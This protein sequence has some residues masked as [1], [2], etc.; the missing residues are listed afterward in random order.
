MSNAKTLR[1]RTT[2]LIAAVTL[3]FA[4]TAAKAAPSADLW[5]R[6]LP[7]DPVSPIT[8]DHYEW[9]RMLEMYLKPGADGVNRFDYGA[10]TPHDRATF[11]GYLDS[12]SQVPI[13]QCR[14]EEQL[15]FWINLYNALTV[16]T[17]L[18]H[19][20]VDSIRD[21]DISPGLFSK[22]PWKRK[23]FTVEGEA[24][25][26]DDIEH[27]ILRPVWQD[28]R[29]HY[30]LNCA[31]VGCP[32]LNQEAFTA[33]NAEA[34]MEASA[35]AYVNSP[36]GVSVNARGLTLSSIFRWYKDDFGDTEEAL[37][38]HIAQ[39]ADEPL[40]KVLASN[41]RIRG[42]HYDWRLNDLAADVSWGPPKPTYAKAAA[43]PWRYPNLSGIAV[44]RALEIEPFEK[45][46]VGTGRAFD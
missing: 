8:V 45:P 25:S 35:R 13:S 33:D 6:W 38:A 26:L 40:A 43:L 17:V 5:D 19:Y 28:P 22:G 7:H 14:R 31:A 20:P 12:L 10:V 39:F 36:H 18:D 3:L 9:G 1:S 30:V 16:N 24:V 23:L 21:I 37:L 4:A 34:L 27:R 32:Q 11:L 2:F 41:P 15:A 44:G 42:Y 29:M 46:R